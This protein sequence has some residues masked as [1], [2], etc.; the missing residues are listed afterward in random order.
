MRK[1]L[2]LICIS[3]LPPLAGCSNDPIAVRLPWVYRIDIQQ[4]NVISQ[5]EINQLE[6]GMSQRQVLFIMGTPA[7]AD[8]FHA[9]R[10]DYVYLFE[11]GETGAETEHQQI[12]LF[13]ENDRLV[14]LM[15]DFRPETDA[16]RP[17]RQ[18]TVTVP[19]QQ[20]GGDG[21]LTR[22]WHWLGFGRN[23]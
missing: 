2:I 9:G 10:W 11:P 18:V 22:F 1:L 7:I 21:I 19:P 20:R 14:R 15:G 17:D 6:P 3:A 23:G 13:F 8:P 12:S 16:P 5:N 4:G